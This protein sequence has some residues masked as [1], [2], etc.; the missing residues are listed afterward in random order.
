MQT[1][2]RNK[3]LT[4]RHV[5]KRR[6]KLSKRRRKGRK[7]D[8]GQEWGRGPSAERARART[9]WQIIMWED[10]QRREEEKIERRDPSRKRERGK[11]ECEGNRGRGG[12]KENKLEE[13][14]IEGMK[15]ERT[16]PDV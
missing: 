14:C 9:I 8:V 1:T 12:E 2:M 10:G 11:I 13:A 16:F 15:W 6:Y 5:R 3:P 7:R 4:D